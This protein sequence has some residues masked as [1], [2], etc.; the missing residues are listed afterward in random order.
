MQTYQN[1]LFLC[2]SS[3]HYICYFH[4]LYAVTKKKSWKCGYQS[5][6]LKIKYRESRSNN[7]DCID[8]IIMDVSVKSVS[9]FVAEMQTMGN[10]SIQWAFNSEHFGIFFFFGG[11]AY[12]QFYLILLKNFV[13]DI[14]LNF[15][16]LELKNNFLG[17][18][19]HA[20]ATVVAQ[21]LLL[22]SWH[23]LCSD[24]TLSKCLV[25]IM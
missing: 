1:M 10:K 24:N 18:S 20:W 3:Q 12:F 6:C 2:C 21:T 25:L 19:M 17:F 14:F 11:G 4:L 13:S 22:L 8:N 9:N 23:N 15:F 5:L 16:I 7:R